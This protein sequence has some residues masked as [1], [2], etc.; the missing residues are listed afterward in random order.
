MLYI[1]ANRCVIRWKFDSISERL[2]APIIRIKE[3][4]KPETSKNQAA[5]RTSSSAL[6]K[7]AVFSSET[8]ENF[9]QSTRSNISENTVVLFIITAVTISFKSLEYLKAPANDGFLKLQA[10]LN[11]FK[12]ISEFDIII[13]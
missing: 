7:E 12:M 1:V 11:I 9:C 2:T 6:V 8:T 13:F 3:Q 4:V 10:V 5:S